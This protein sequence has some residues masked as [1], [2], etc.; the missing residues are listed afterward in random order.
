MQV[1]GLLLDSGGAGREE[2]LLPST[3]G[4]IRCAP[5]PLPPPQVKGLLLDSEVL[6]AK[7]DYYLKGA[8]VLVGTPELLAAALAPPEGVEAV[9]HADV[10]C[11]DEVD[12]CFQVG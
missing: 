9:Q 1:K 3:A 11:V 8:H 12:A 7:K 6:G 4:L 10:V 5:R 2:G